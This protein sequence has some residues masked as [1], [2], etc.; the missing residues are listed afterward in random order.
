M[1]LRYFRY[2]F[3]CNL[4]IKSNQYQSHK[5]EIINIQVNHIVVKFSYHANPSIEE[6]QNVF[7][8]LPEVV[9]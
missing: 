6:S 2:S 4:I 7:N 9:F 8:F 1:F 3:D 5:S